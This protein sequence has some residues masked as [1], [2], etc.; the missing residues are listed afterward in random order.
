MFKNLYKIDQYVF[1]L[2]P[3]SFNRFPRFV[4]YVLFVSIIKLKTTPVIS[5]KMVSSSFILPLQMY[6]LYNLF[7]FVNAIFISIFIQGGFLELH[8]IISCGRKFPKILSKVLLNRSTLSFMLR[9]QKALFQSKDPLVHD[10]IAKIAF[11][12]L[13][14]NVL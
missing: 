6:F 3:G 8:L 7:F 5:C 14:V 12:M 13:G 2:V 11:R 10:Y 4:K 1:G 9:P